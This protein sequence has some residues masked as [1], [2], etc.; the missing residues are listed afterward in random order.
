[1]IDLNVSVQEIMS[2]NLKSVGPN[3]LL[4]EIDTIFKNNNF[5]HLPVLNEMGGVIGMISKTDYHKLQHHFTL[6]NYQEAQDANDKF[7]ESLLA[8]EIM[9]KNPIVIHKGTT[10]KETIKMLLRNEFHSLVVIEDNK[11]IG[12][13]TPHDILKFLIRDN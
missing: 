5:H 6:F 4:S 12:L 2:K 7:F 9:N 3:T 10:I 13:V 8:E 11:S 1:M